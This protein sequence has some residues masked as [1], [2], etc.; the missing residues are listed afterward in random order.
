MAC[1]STTLHVNVC[2]CVCRLKG[3]E[4]EHW[5]NETLNSLSVPESSPCHCWLRPGRSVAGDDEESSCPF[6]HANE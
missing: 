4:E 2:V 6:L 3:Q 1:Y 5:P